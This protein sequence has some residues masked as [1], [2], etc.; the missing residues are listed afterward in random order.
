MAKVNEEIESEIQQ[1]ELELV[2]LDDLPG[3]LT[4]VSGSPRSLVTLR[5]YLRRRLDV[6]RP[7]LHAELCVRQGPEGYWKLEGVTYGP[8]GSM[9]ITERRVGVPAADRPQSEPER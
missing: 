7:L 8:N 9:T 5:D 6:L 3:L 4:G 2:K 1:L